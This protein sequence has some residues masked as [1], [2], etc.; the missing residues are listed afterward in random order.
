MAVACVS[1]YFLGYG[2]GAGAGSA[3]YVDVFFHRS[4]LDVRML[5][6]SGSC[7]YVMH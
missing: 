5:K 1:A 6:M 2:G 4:L 3:E 7:I